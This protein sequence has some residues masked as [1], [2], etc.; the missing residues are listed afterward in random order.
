M[1]GGEIVDELNA[2]G[3]EIILEAVED[4]YHFG[5]SLITVGI[6]VKDDL[7]LF[8]GIVGLFEHLDEIYQIVNLIGQTDEGV[9]NLDDVRR[10]EIVG[11]Q[12]LVRDSCLIE[13]DFDGLGGELRPFLLCIQRS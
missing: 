5:N 11:K 1:V 10:P 9:G 6:G 12:C 4:V 7:Q 13:T 8:R 2:E 3:T